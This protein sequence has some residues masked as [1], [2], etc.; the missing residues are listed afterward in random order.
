MIFHV[1]DLNGN[2]AL[3]SQE[4]QLFLEHFS[5]YYSCLARNML[6]VELANCIDNEEM[7]ELL[8]RLVQKA[9][10]RLAAQAGGEESKA[11]HAEMMQAVDVDQ[12]QN[13]SFEELLENREMLPSLVNKLL[14]LVVNIPKGG[15]LN[16]QEASLLH[17][18][19]QAAD[20]SQDEGPGSYDTSGTASQS[21]NY[22]PSS[23]PTRSLDEPRIAPKS[24]CLRASCG[25]GSRFGSPYVDMLAPEHARWQELHTDIVNTIPKEMPKS[26]PWQRSQEDRMA[27]ASPS[28]VK[29]ASGSPSGSFLGSTRGRPGCRHSSGGKGCGFPSERVWYKDRVL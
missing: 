28:P 23:T 3:S 21:S 18:D 16:Y 11:L 6:R 15:T 7:S 19:R 14:S 5:L 20:A 4:V 2:N 22:E 26:R 12:D 24:P 10:N 13:I 29:S 8:Q 17:F 27:A 9:E 25:T 1:M